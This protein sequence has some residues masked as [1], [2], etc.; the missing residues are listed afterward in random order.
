MKRDRL[1]VLLVLVTI[2][3]SSTVGVARANQRVLQRGM[4]GNDVRELQENLVMLGEKIIIDGIFGEATEEAIKDFQ[5]NSDLPD[6]GVVGSQ[7]W[8][9]LEQALS[10]DEHTVRRGDNLSRL[11]N[12]YGVSLD[13][14]REAND[15][16]SDILQIGQE[17][18]IPKSGLGGVSTTEFYEFIEYQVRSGDTLERLAREYNT[19][20]RRIREENDLRTDRIIPGQKIT[21]PKLMINLPE[22]SENVESVE[23][24]FIW[25]VEGRITSGFA[26]RVNPISNQ[27]QFHNGIDIA[28][29]EGTPVK[30]TRAGEVLSSGWIRGYGKT[31]TI[32]H[33]N[34]VVTLYAH[35]SQLSVRSGQRVEQ[36]EV[37]ARAGSTGQST[38]PHVHFEIRI[39]GDPANPKDY[40][41]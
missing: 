34:G 23:R 36:G 26:W 21:I 20:V 12:T 40:L 37:I 14:I 15:L 8:A 38:G 31:V 4:R 39:D 5:R 10:F 16:S 11:A 25:P 22:T 3:I 17:L 1:I 9:R 35:N 13:V 33:G 24:D 28:V 30:A 7:T 41:E 6:D 29:P 18:I 32:D 27:R 2:I 19:T